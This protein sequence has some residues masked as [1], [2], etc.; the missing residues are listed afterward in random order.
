[1]DERE[2]RKQR[3]EAMKAAITARDRAAVDALLAQVPEEDRGNAVWVGWN[4]ADTP[5]AVAFM[6]SISPWD[7]VMLE[8]LL[9]HGSVETVAGWFAARAG[10][11]VDVDDVQRAFA[12]AC[13]AGRADLVDLF[14]AHGGAVNKAVMAHGSGPWEADGNIPFLRAIHAGHL[15]VVQKLA[16]AGAFINGRTAANRTPLEA[17]EAAGQETIAAWLRSI[18]GTAL[19]EQYW[20]AADA[21]ARGRPDLVPARLPGSSPEARLAALVMA[22]KGPDAALFAAVLAAVTDPK[23]RGLTLITVASDPALIDRLDALLAAGTDPNATLGGN[24]EGPDWTPIKAAVLA[25]NVEAV[26]KLLAAGVDKDFKHFGWQRP[27]HLAVCAPWGGNGS[28]PRVDVLRPGRTEYVGQTIPDQSEIVRLLASLGADL[29]SPDIEKRSPLALAERW[30]NHAG[31][32][33]LRELIG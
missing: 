18:G 6:V 24:F 31:A 7:S 33:L 10:E 20:S 27:I 14:L 22:A 8:N 16:R 9:E 15:D 1:M 19:D 28:I 29:V 12:Q 11:E 23:A 3:R 2:A 17:A 13:A 21:I 5:E 30:D 4:M 25:N 26:R 32:A